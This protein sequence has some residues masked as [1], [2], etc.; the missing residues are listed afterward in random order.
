[1]DM[2][3]AILQRLRLVFMNQSIVFDLDGT[4]V[5]NI[6]YEEV[7]DEVSKCTGI[8]FTEL[9]ANYR[10]NWKGIDDAIAYHLG[11]CASEEGKKKIL[12]AY[13]NFRQAKSQPSVN[14]GAVEIL[15]KLKVM[16]KHLVCWTQGDEK[17]QRTVLTNADLFK[18]FSAVAVVPTKTAPAVIQHLL[19]LVG[20]RTFA[21]IG[22]YIEMDLLPVSG[23]AND[24]VWISQSRASKYRP[25][26]EVLPANIME[27]NHLAD[28][29]AAI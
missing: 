27:V 29:L 16:G 22:D 17:F 9:W 12:Q 5:E 13:E 11:L 7:C 8:S 18:Y 20:Q 2:T 24:R 3:P 10:A 21:M 1:M 14:A 26:P 6:P 25:R 4:L 15:S 23:W 28:L 19:P